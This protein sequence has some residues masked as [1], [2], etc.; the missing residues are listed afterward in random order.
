MGKWFSRAA[1][2]AGAKLACAAA[3]ACALSTP[4]AEGQERR[5]RRT[6]GLVLETGAPHA[7]CDVVAFTR[8]GD[9]LLTAGDDKVVRRWKMGAAAIGEAERVLRW[10]IFREARGGIHA[11]ALSRDAKH[12]AVTGLGVKNGLVM[13]LDRTSGAV[14][15]VLDEDL[16]PGANWA[17]AW[18]PDGRFVIFGNEYGQVFRWEPAAKANGLIRFAGTGSAGNAINRVRLLAF[19][20]ASRFL[21]VAQD[22]KVWWRNVNT[23]E[24]AAA[25]PVAAFPLPH[26]TQRISAAAYSPVSGLLAACAED[27]RLKVDV[28]DLKPI[29]AGAAGGQARLI[30][31]PFPEEDG[32]ERFGWSLA[33]NSRGDK[34]AVGTREANKGKEVP[35]FART[36]GGSVLVYALG[37]AKPR[38]LTPDDGLACGCAVDA[39]AFRPGSDQIA[40]AGGPN[41]EVRLWANERATS[42]LSTLRGPGSCLWSVA[43]DAKGKYLAWREQMN[44]RP[45]GPNDRGA[46]EWRYFKLDPKTRH[47][48]SRPPA[49]FT[50][51][52]AIETL[53]GWRVQTT[54]DS[55]VWNVLEPP[56]AG[57]TEPTAHELSSSAGTYLTHRNGLPRCY[58]FLPPIDGKPV[59]LAVGHMWGVSIYELRP[60]EVRLARYLSGH[61]GEVTAV[62]PSA[63]GKLLY[64]ASRDQTIACWSLADW[65][66]QAELGASF[67]VEK[68]RLRVAAVAPGSPAWEMGLTD[69]DEVVLVLSADRFGPGGFL[70]NPDNLDLK[71]LKLKMPEKPRPP[72]DD[73]AL[74]SYLDRAEAARE[75]IFFWRHGG[76]DAPLQGQLTTLPQRPL[77]RF[78]PTRRDEGSNWVLWRWRDYYY[79]TM[80]PRPDRLLGWH[81]YDHLNLKVAPTFHPLGHFSSRCD[82][83]GVH[84]EGFRDPDRVWKYIDA[85]NQQPELVIFPAI[86]PPRIEVLEVLKPAPDKGHDLKLDVRVAPHDSRAPLQAIYRISVWIDDARF[87]SPKP[88]DLDPKTRARHQT[89]VIPRD[90][91]RRG[92]NRIKVVAFNAEGGRAERAVVVPFADPSRGK[93]A[94]HALCV[95]LDDY[96]N[97]KNLGVGNLSCSEADAKALQRVL[98]QHQ[99]SAVYGD[100]KIDSLLG[101]QVTRATVLA[102]L[103]T[104]Q[105][106]ARADDWVVL[107]LSGH[108]H[109][110]AGK[111]AGA[112]GYVC[113]DSDGD[114]EATLLT[115]DDLHVALRDVPCRK[116]VILDACRSGHVANSPI[117]GLN[118]DGIEF[119]IF[120]ACKPHQEALEPNPTKARPVLKGRFRPHGVFTWS[121]MDALGWPEEG[122]KGRPRAVTDKE[123]ADRVCGKMKELLT[124]L[125]KDDDAQEPE[126]FP[127]RRELRGLVLLSRP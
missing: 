78:F 72:F 80:S 11:M 21:S 69:D 84:V 30:P 108:G 112:F 19:T 99:N 16:G 53:G 127:E 56:A 121:L 115:A 3:L 114:D 105:E 82:R 34:L 6:P 18:S 1:A 87:A 86:E 23:P 116:L 103:R 35:P 98:E 118:K 101:P 20:D 85:T 104:I 10:P 83:R 97:V 29:L 123:L 27:Q 37:G 88:W 38:L 73:V 60:G 95:G 102:R 28:L 45:K 64:T 71:K 52:T 14:V 81:V 43:I 48:L 42:S 15:H 111:G 76:K 5:G 89:L 33:F 50:P 26:E 17:I 51:R 12:V 41:H 25:A 7:T 110:R 62:A 124:L 36:T 106:R 126:F 125:E 91:L 65:P 113:A 122:V 9:E 70:Y 49:D 90:R 59:R 47:I 67:R 2:G 74:R 66:N 55:Y 39:L 32:K 120:S 57:D 109:V 54:N 4:S 93:P 119:R 24:R 31:L 92:D 46:G 79:D 8:S 40:T 61:E 100:A 117:R 13:V 22:G 75:H 68:G 63:N 94:L 77:W 107:F 44:T 58:T 96:S